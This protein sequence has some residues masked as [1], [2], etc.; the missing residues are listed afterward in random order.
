MT[1][2]NCGCDDGCEL[3]FGIDCL[4]WSVTTDKVIELVVDG[5]AWTDRASGLERS[6]EWPSLEG[7]CTA[8]DEPS[9]AGETLDFPGESIA[10]SPVVRSIAA[11]DLESPVELRPAGDIASSDRFGSADSSIS[12]AKTG[13]G[14]GEAT[15]R[16]GSKREASRG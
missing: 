13:A 8:N 15:E 5:A 12:A 2:G 1:D 16:V 11:G 6:S 4:V 9:G 10:R 3:A 7:T 14:A